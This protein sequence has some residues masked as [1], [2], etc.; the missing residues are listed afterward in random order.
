V[1]SGWA[2]ALRAQASEGALRCRFTLFGGKRLRYGWS[3]KAARVSYGDG[4]GSPLPPQLMRPGSECAIKELVSGGNTTKLAIE[5]Y[6]PNITAVG[7]SK[8]GWT[9]CQ[10]DSLTLSGPAGWAFGSPTAQRETLGEAL[11]AHP[12]NYPNL[13]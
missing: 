9:S 2:H 6:F 12:V 13:P 8:S 10:L 3:L 11:M 7:E 5:V 1:A 4:T